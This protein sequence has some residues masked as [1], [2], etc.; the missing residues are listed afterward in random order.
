MGHSQQD[1]GRTAEHTPVCSSSPH[2]MLQRKVWET[3][4]AGMGP[5]GSL[6]RSVPVATGR[7]AGHDPSSTRMPHSEHLSQLDN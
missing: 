5:A 7:E 1:L 6:G 4:A 3:T 2:W